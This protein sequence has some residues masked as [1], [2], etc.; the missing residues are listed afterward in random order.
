MEPR[1]FTRSLTTSRLVSVAWLALRRNLMGILSAVAWLLMWLP[2]ESGAATLSN[3]IARFEVIRGTNALG[4]MDVELFDQEKPQTVRN[5]LLYVRSG[6]YTNGFIHRNVPGFA[7]QGGGFTVND[8]AATNLFSA[9]NAVTTFGNLTNEFLVGARLTNLFGTIAM[10]KLGGDADSATS[11]WFF[12]LANNS[13]NLDNQNGGFTVFGRA[14]ESTN[15]TDGTNVLTHF[16]SLS[17]NS[18]IANLGN[19]IGSS[20]SVFS[21]LPVAVSNRPPRTPG[22]DGLY[23]TRI[24]ILNDPYVAGTNTPSIDLV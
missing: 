21:D 15:A 14:L 11:Q 9:Y 16:N 7:A 2:M 22:Y 17:T 13:T 6:A 10:A 3:T 12:N 1:L 20:Y 23:L 18:T 8:P 5:F 19:L 24:T 4:T